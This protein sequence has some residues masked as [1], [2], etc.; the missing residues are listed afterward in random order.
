MF[1]RCLLIVL[2]VHSTSAF[3]AYKWDVKFDLTV[4]AQYVE[5]QT[6]QARNFGIAPAANFNVQLLE[7]LS[8]K[9]RASALLEA[10][11]YKGTLLD[12][13]KP[14]QQV[15]LNHAYFNYLPWQSMQA[16]R[17]A[18]PMKTWTPDM[19]ISSTRFLGVNGIQKISLWSDAV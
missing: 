10:G 7:N 13:F 2:V 5:G 9:A 1:L 12:E 8:F 6:Q 14:D 18:S 3:A 15:V 4:N 16:Q 19:L 11:S 17:G